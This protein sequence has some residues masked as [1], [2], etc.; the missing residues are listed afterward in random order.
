MGHISMGVDISSDTGSRQATSAASPSPVRQ[1]YDKTNEE[2][3]RFVLPL[4]V[5][6]VLSLP[7]L[8]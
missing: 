8:V 4:S 5:M 2:H 7:E 6:F 3:V 1:P